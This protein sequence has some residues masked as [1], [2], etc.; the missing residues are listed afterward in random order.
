MILI[1]N[2]ILN[3]IYINFY[4]FLKAFINIHTQKKSRNRYKNEESSKNKSWK[5]ISIGES[6][7]SIFNKFI[8]LNKVYRVYKKVFNKNWNL[9]LSC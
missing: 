8:F 6:L 9:E 4:K 1:L 2:F 5:A 7:L 3:Q